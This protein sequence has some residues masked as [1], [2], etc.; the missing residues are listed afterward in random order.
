M[1]LLLPSLTLFALAFGLS[2]TA[3][4]FDKGEV[5]VPAP[6]PADTCT[7]TPVTR[8]IE[9]AN[10]VFIPDSVNACVGDT[11]KWQLTAGTHTTTSTTV[12]SGAATWDEFMSSSTST[13]YTYIVTVAGNYDY[14]C[15]IHP[16][17]TGKIVVK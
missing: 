5:A 9:V 8:I 12:P 13:T 7:G 11:I 17:M 10:N 6:A 14:V 4:T 16:S 2:F 1:K 3:C 15:T